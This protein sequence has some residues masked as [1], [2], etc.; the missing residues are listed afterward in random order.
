M[1]TRRNLVKLVTMNLDFDVDSS[2]ARRRDRSAI[3]FDGELIPL[4][5]TKFSVLCCLVRPALKILL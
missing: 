4:P 1:E 3:A 2:F 5:E